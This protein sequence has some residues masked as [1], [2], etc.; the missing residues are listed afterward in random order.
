MHSHFRAK[1]EKANGALAKKKNKNRE[2]M[3][4]VT[5]LRRSAAKA[6]D[7]ASNVG[8]AMDVYGLPEKS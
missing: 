5:E 3:E 4:M 1:I 8:E 2:V 6:S 7:F